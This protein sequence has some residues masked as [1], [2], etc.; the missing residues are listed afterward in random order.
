MNDIKHEETCLDKIS[1][2]LFQTES[3]RIELSSASNYNVLLS[4]IE[5]QD[6]ETNK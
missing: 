4:D 2:M 6:C 1:T 5:N 3:G